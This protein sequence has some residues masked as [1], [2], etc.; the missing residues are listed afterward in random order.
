MS[1]PRT[2]PIDRLALLAWG[3]LLH[4]R[5][6]G[7]AGASGKM[8]QR[9]YA[10]RLQEERRLAETLRPEAALEIALLVES[11][12]VELSTNL[13]GRGWL[14]EGSL[15]A[16]GLG[17]TPV[18]P[19]RHA[20]PTSPLWMEGG[21]P[22]DVVLGVDP[23]RRMEIFRCLTDRLGPGCTGVIPNYSRWPEPDDRCVGFVVHEEGGAPALGRELSW[24]RE[25]A[26]YRRLLAARSRVRESYSL[27][28]GPQASAIQTA[29]ARLGL[30]VD[31]V[32]LDDERVFRI[33][34]S[35]D[36]RGF[37]PWDAPKARTILQVLT[38]T[39]F[40]ELVI[41]GALYRANH[42]KYKKVGA[43]IGRKL[44]GRWR[45]RHPVVDPILA[46][47]CGTWVFSEQCEDALRAVTGLDRS[48]AYSF[49]GRRTTDEDQRSMAGRCVAQMS[50]RHRCT[51][52]VARSV[53][54][55]LVVAARYSTMRGIA[56]HN[57]L[58]GYLTAWI[59]V[60]GGVGRPRIESGPQQEGDCI[61]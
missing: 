61:G 46:D 17:L 15:L 16:F 2:R 11:L 37:P 41:L 25:E 29:L 50:E 40:E 36:P 14:L 57:A 23:L 39:R 20:I 43:Y 10:D 59:Q 27:S 48:E 58:M 5:Q 56:V 18:D 24:D 60:R 49:L 26:S 38:P 34:S 22:V 6:W 47:T 13:W 32:P 52:K 7:K 19:V 4:R 31:D 53:L 45:R 8:A 35:D 51:P 42:S 54:G 30:Q 1:F 33:L 3:R 9:V 21:R 12:T 28:D 44:G 55:E